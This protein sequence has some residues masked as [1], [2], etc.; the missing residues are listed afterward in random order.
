MTDGEMKVLDDFVRYVKE[1]ITRLQGNNY[2][3]WELTA[4]YV[5]VQ[6]YQIQKRLA[7]Q[8][9]TSTVEEAERI[10]DEKD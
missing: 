1:N 3:N 2:R 5:M 7:F 8:L 6:L 4:L 9:G 10:L